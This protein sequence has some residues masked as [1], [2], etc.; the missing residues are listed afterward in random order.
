MIFDANSPSAQTRRP[1]RSL[2]LLA[3]ERFAEFDR[4][5]ASGKLER[6]LEWTEKCLQN[7]PVQRVAS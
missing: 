1:R 5:V 7:A 4:L 2:A 6:V 3:P